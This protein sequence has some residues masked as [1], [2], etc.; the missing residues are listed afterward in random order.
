MRLW[1]LLLPAMIFSGT[2]AAPGQVESKV[3]QRAEDLR[4][5]NNQQELANRAAEARNVPAPAPQAQP[6]VVSAVDAQLSQNLETITADLAAMR[7]ATPANNAKGSF[8][9]DFE[10]LPR[11]SVWPPAPDLKKLADDLS[12]SLAGVNLSQAEQARLARAINVI[13]NRS[14]VTSDQAKSFVSAAQVVLKANNVPDSSIQTVIAD[15]N[16][17][18]DDVEQ[19]MPK[20]YFQ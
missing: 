4:N 18:N 2:V 8:E 20:L 14:M 7:S 17:I 16:A 11:A 3:L 13:V 1:I 10:N 12:A 15:L 9:G 6:K 5:A 19:K